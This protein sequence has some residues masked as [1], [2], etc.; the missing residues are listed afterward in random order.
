VFAN[1]VEQRHAE[2]ECV[3]MSAIASSS[4][5]FPH[6]PVKIVHK[7]KPT[8]SGSFENKEFVLRA[9]DEVASQNGW[10]R[11]TSHWLSQKRDDK[12]PDAEQLQ[13]AS[14]VNGIAQCFG[15]RSL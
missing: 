1:R 7:P 8:S 14:Y 10:E 6:K 9:D 13:R 15:A 12:F 4:V 2:M 5:K 3:R 11:R